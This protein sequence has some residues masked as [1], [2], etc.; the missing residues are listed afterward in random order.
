[1]KAL[2]IIKKNAVQILPEQELEKKLKSQK[3]LKIK[4]GM[5][6]TAPDLHLGHAVV[7]RKMREFQDLGH[8]VIFLVG[9][10]TARI[11]DPTGRSKTRPPLTEEEIKKNTQTYFE[12]VKKILNP[13]TVTIRHN[14]EW[15]DLLPIKEM[16]KLCAKVTLARLT[17]RE[18]FATRIV[19]QTPIG[20]HELL[21]P[22]FQG[23]DSVALKSD[24]ELGGTDQTFNLLM[25]RFLQEQYG[26]EPQVILTMPLL[27]GLDGINKMSK[28][29]GNAVGID[30][31]ADQAYGKLMSI[32]DE[33][34]WHYFGLLLNKTSQEIESM[35]HTVVDG[36]RHPMDLKKQMAHGIIEAFWSKK[37]ADAAQEQFEAVFQKRDYSKAQQVAFARG[38]DN[39][40]WIIDFL[41]LFG[42]IT[43]SSEGRR[44][45]Q[46]GAVSID[47]EVIKDF[48]AQ[49][50]W[51]SGMH[52]KAGKHKIYT[53]K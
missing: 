45:I 24:V 20:F 21:Y 1:M 35:K 46:A 15:L 40:L 52:V 49:V 26:Q 50:F 47:G 44:L 2:E 17:E 29:L 42:A 39:P 25:G 43:T 11:G 16:V 19:S 37:D 18:D 8:D 51:R 9:D 53:I 7:L 3:K 48:K 34:M 14:S 28:S 32:S 10:F 6:P 30:E 5:D 31:P 27:R 33:L 36:S 13:S 23:Y 38:T 41:R 12:Q 4:L 22:L